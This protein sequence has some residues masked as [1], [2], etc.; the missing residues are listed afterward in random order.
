MQIARWFG[1]YRRLFDLRRPVRL[2]LVDVAEQMYGCFY[3]GEKED[4][5]V[6]N[7][8][9]AVTEEE[10][11]STLLHELIHA[12]QHGKGLH[13]D[14]DDYFNRRAAELQALKGIAP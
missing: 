1:Q 3:V 13:L 2:H 11:R 4:L 10:V 7:R 6:L 14:H 8:A 5:I 12:E 9:I